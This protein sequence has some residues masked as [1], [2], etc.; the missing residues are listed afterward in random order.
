MTTGGFSQRAYDPAED[1]T[2]ILMIQRAAGRPTLP[3]FL[4]FFTA[5]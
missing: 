2:A 1:M 4:G 3:M 5:A